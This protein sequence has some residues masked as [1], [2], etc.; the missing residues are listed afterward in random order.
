MQHVLAI[1]LAFWLGFAGCE[2]PQLPFWNGFTQSRNASTNNSTG[3]MQSPIELTSLTARPGIEN[4][5]QLEFSGYQQ[6]PT[7]V[8]VTN[9]GH[10]AVY[11]FNFPEPVVARGGPLQGNYQFSSLHFHWGAESD[12]G[13]EHVVDGK[14]HTMEMHLVFYNQ[15]YG[16]F[17]NA[18]TQC[19]G[20][21][22]LGVFF[23]NSTAEPDYRW[24]PALY[25]VQTAGTS[26]T[27]PDPTAFNIKGLIGARRKPYFSYHGSLTTPPYY[28][29]VTWLVMKKP[30]QVSENQ[31]SAFRSL[32]DEDGNPLVDNYR[33]LQPINGRT[34][35]LYSDTG[36]DRIMP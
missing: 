12:R 28:E 30:L 7:Q 31:M 22:V 24:I 20:L 3:G 5:G 32:K 25:E 27:L 9:D 16:S 33:E 11:S 15:I 19:N 34:I 1:V 13:A 10:T 8:N 18:K 26:Y 4:N 36:F 14:R 35:L 29:S 2:P 23:Q 6:D 17:D 21:A